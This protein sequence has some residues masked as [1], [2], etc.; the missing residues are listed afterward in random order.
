M[1]RSMIVLLALSPLGA[2]A[3]E[4]SAGTV[5]AENAFDYCQAEG[6]DSTSDA[7]ASCMAS[8][9]N[10]TCLKAGPVGTSEYDRCV[11]EQRD[12]ALVRRQL[13]IRGY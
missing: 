8:Y 9:I 10:E 2:C 13:Y 11:D 1:M 5:T 4:D 3:T 6:Y 12:A 7:L